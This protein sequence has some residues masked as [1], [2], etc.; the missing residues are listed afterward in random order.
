M[1]VPG[2][3]T[4]SSCHLGENT[5]HSGWLAHMTVICGASTL[6]QYFDLAVHPEI[7]FKIRQMA[8]TLVIQ[9]ERDFAIWDTRTG[10]LVS[11][12]DLGNGKWSFSPDGR[13]IAA[14]RKSVV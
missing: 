8:I 4:T 1:W 3:E 6:K 9:R 12:L 5:F 10:T 2:F 7:T 14:D 13:Y 11:I